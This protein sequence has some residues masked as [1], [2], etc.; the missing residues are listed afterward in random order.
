MMKLFYQRSVKE[1]IGPHF[2]LELELKCGERYYP[3]SALTSRTG[4]LLKL[5]IHTQQFVHAEEGEKAH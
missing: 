1:E 3:Y 5:N 2:I 4:R